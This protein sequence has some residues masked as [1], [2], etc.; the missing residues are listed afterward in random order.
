MGVTEVISLGEL[1]KSVFFPQAVGGEPF[2]G[3]AVLGVDENGE[4]ILAVRSGRPA[5][6]RAKRP[7]PPERYTHQARW[8]S[9]WQQNS[10]GWPVGW[11][12]NRI[13]SHFVHL[14]ELAAQTIE[15]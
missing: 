2:E 11:T 3:V 15:I 7:S 9:R 1:A 12:P 5:P 8:D 13:S 10:A 14:T 4:P 6:S